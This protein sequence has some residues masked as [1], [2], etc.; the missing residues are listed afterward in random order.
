M[1]GLVAD[2]NRSIATLAITTLL[3]IGTY[4]QTRMHTDI[5]VGCPSRSLHHPLNSAKRYSSL[6]YSPPSLIFSPPLLPSSP[7]PPP[8]VLLSSPPTPN[9]TPPLFLSVLSQFPKQIFTSLTLP[10]SHTGNESSID[11]LMKQISSFMAEIGDEFKIVVVKA[12]RELCVKYPAKHRSMV[13]TLLIHSPVIYVF[14]HSFIVYYIFAYS[15]IY[16]L[17]H[18]N[19]HLPFITS[20]LFS[21]LHSYHSYNQF[22]FFIF[23]PST[24]SSISLS[25]LPCQPCHRIQL[26]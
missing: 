16:V 26:I 3:K 8:I 6:L 12:I 4:I 5:A 9:P 22:H 7:L 23:F 18:I 2:S 13:P 17:M 20:F 19:V 14:I 10:L 21:F 1:E 24:H 15:D 11:R 25:S